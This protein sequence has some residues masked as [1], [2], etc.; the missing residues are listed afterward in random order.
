MSVDSVFFSIYSL[1][2]PYRVGRGGNEIGNG[3]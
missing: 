3:G 1:S 2:P